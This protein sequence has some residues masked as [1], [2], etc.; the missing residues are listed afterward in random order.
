MNEKKKTKEQLI[1]EPEKLKERVRELEKRDIEHLQKEKAW[2]EERKLLHGLLDN[3]PN[4]HIFLKD[5]E[6]RLLI[7]NRYLLRL[8]GRARFEEV[9]GKTDFDFFPRELAEQYYKDEQEIIHSGVA[10]IDR[11]EK[12][13]DSE[14]REYWLSTTKVPLYS[15]EGKIIGIAGVS[16][17]ITK[18]K[19]V[20]GIVGFSHDITV[21]KKL[22][23]ERNRLILELQDALAKIKTLT[24]VLPICASCKKIRDGQGYWHQMECYVRDHSQVTF[25]HGIC[26]ACTKKLL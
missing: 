3:I 10:I 4:C 11:E 22:E 2:K 1:V 8:L 21:R 17:D 9:I 7:T 12:T 6:S 26:P 16:Q 25:T 19:N 13:I 23:E 24:G 15:E 18:Y 20:V 5:K 14:G